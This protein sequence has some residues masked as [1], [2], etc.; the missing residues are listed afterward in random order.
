M[1]V[2]S[3]ASRA[4]CEPDHT[5]ACHLWGCTLRRSLVAIRDDS[6]TGDAADFEARPVKVE[7]RW[8]RSRV[9]S[10]VR[11]GAHL[12]CRVENLRE[13]PSFELQAFRNIPPNAKLDNR[14]PIMF[15]KKLS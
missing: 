6:G 4:Q 5:S 15:R 14:G 8:S 10:A 7:D 11:E 13:L 9:S 3:R 2:P 1:E 12:A